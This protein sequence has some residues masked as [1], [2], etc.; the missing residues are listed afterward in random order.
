MRILIDADYYLFRAATAAE[1]EVEL[2]PDCWTYL[3]RITDAKDSF[4]AEVDRFQAIAPDHSPVLILGHSSNFRY[5]IY[6][7]YKSNRRKYR[8]PAGLAAFRDWAAK[9]WPSLTLANVEGDDV[10]GVMA[11]TGDIIVSR[12]KDLRTIPGLHLEGAGIIDV[13]LWEADF[14]FYRQILTGDATDGYPGCKGIGPI[15]AAQLLAECT[16]RLEMWQA[17]LKAY[18]KAG[19]EIDFAIQMARCA[20]ILRPGEYDHNKQTPILWNPP[21]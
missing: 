17:V 20:R 13:S 7:D 18:A 15:K 5:A 6:P 19:L 21:T 16:T 1:Y 4:E 10:L 8:R 9:N 12:D 11:E 2:T 14:N 3:C